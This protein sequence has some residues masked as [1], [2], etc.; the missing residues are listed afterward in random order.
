MEIFFGFLG[1]LSKLLKLLLKITKVTTGHQK[2]PKMGQNRII[3]SFF[4]QRAKKASAEGQSPPQ[5]LEVGPRS[6]PYLLVWL[7]AGFIFMTNS[8]D[9]TAFILWQILI[10]FTREV[11]ADSGWRI[12]WVITTNTK[13]QSA[14]SQVNY[15][16]LFEYYTFSLFQTSPCEDGWQQEKIL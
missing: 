7:I 10:T 14:P 6:W 12:S 8:I 13:V 1:F 15:S 2:L 11:G 4:A 5:E 3:T 9:S 16:L